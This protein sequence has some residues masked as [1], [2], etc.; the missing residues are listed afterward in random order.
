MAKDRPP[1]FQFYPADFLSDGSV[2]AMTLEARG[3]YITLLCAAWDSETPGVLPDDDAYLAGLSD[4]RD[5]WPEIRA[6]VAR[7]FVVRGGTWTQKRMVAE[8][9]AQSRRYRQSRNGAL[10]TNGARWGSVA[11]RPDSESLS[12][13]TAVAPSSSSSSSRESKTKIA[14]PAPSARPDSEIGTTAEPPRPPQANGTAPSC[15]SELELGSEHVPD[16]ASAPEPILSDR[17]AEVIDLLRGT[18]AALR[19]PARISGKLD[20]ARV[21]KLAEGTGREVTR[22]AI[23]L[24]QRWWNAGCRHDGL[25][26]RL[27]GVYL[28]RRERIANPFA[29]FNGPKLAE[30]RLA[31]AARMAEDEHAA[32]MALE[33]RFAAEV[34]G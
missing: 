13:R 11:Q 3:A 22:T 9:E 12:D 6:Q 19:M 26:D 5:R 17:R 29:Y 20:V 21:A 4:A 24:A 2:R 33:R 30:I 15:H 8:R 18:T 28:E 27:V 25:I 16:P 32:C 1:S 31:A 10:V 23:Q 7:A 14:P 34:K